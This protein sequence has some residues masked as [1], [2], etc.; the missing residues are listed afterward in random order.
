MPAAA[1]TFHGSVPDY[2]G[3]GIIDSGETARYRNEFAREHRT[4]RRGSGLGGLPNFGCSG[5]TLTK[6]KTN[7]NA[8]QWK[9][10]R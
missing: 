4:E 7:T 5:G 2:N 6:V 3:N 1:E 10:A 9:C 8:L